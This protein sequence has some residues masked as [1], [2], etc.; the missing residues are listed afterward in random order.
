MLPNI[1]KPTFHGDFDIIRRLWLGIV[2][3]TVFPGLSELLL[4]P[5]WAFKVLKLLANTICSF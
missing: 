4:L 3:E 2:F 1:F 5:Q